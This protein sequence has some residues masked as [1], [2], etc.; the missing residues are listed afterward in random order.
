[1]IFLVIII[2]K[3]PYQA[4]LKKAMEATTADL[5]DCIHQGDDERFSLTLARSGHKLIFLISY[6]EKRTPSSAPG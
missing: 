5:L 2:E 6:R 1:M 3:R 4:R